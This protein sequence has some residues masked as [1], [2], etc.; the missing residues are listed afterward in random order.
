LFVAAGDING[1]GRAEVITSNRTGRARVRI[2]DG[3][4]IA[5]GTPVTPIADFTAGPAGNRTGARV[6]F[7]P[8][9]E[10]DPTALVV[11]RGDRGRVTVYTLADDSDESPNTLF[12][13]DMLEASSGVF[14]G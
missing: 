1:D 5:N 12:D 14:V 10:D 7:K 8:A 3:V 4:G 11:G 9:H 6:A 13:L 2:F